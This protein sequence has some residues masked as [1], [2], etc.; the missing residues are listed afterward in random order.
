MKKPRNKTADT[1]KNRPGAAYSAGSRLATVL[2]I[3][4]DRNDTELFQAAAGRAQACFSI[5]NVTDGE[6][7]MAYL[8]GRGVYANR[9]LYPLPV[10]VLLDLKMPRATGFD[11][12]KWIRNHPEVG[13]LPVVILSGSELRDDVQRAYA[14]GADSYLVKPIGFN[15]LVDLVRTIEASWIAG[16]TPGPE[17]LGASRPGSGWSP[18]DWCQ[19]AA[20]AGADARP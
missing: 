18:L 13:T 11:V 4:D 20:S 19:G 1:R 12:L 2:H 7:A 16:R 17:V 5:Q 3:D 15:A 14:V 8:N 9:Q 10:L 6:Q